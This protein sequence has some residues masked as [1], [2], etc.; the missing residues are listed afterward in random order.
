MRGIIAWFKRIFGGIGK[1]LEKNRTLAKAALRL[2]LG[3]FLERNRDYADEVLRALKGLRDLVKEGKIA[4]NDELRAYI[5]SLTLDKDVPVYLAS[6][7]RDVVDAVFSSIDDHVHLSGGQYK[8]LW[9]DVIE[10]GISMAELYLK[11]A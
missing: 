11:N 7:I 4:T 8:D 3:A 5:A 9:L 10:A 2:S 1:I 6:S